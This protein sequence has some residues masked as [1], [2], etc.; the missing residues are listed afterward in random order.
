MTRAGCGELRMLMKRRM[1]QF[2]TTVAF[3]TK[4]PDR[5]ILSDIVTRDVE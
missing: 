5:S 1:S 2:I 4:A 3:K